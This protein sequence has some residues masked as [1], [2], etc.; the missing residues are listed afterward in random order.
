MAFAF[1]FHV[2]TAASADNEI[3]ALDIE[4]GFSVT[5]QLQVDVVGLEV[6]GDVAVS[7]HL[8]GH[9]FTVELLG[10]Y[11]AIPIDDDV[12]FGTIHVGSLKVAVTIDFD[13]KVAC[14]LRR[15]GTMILSL[16]LGKFRGASLATT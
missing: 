3:V 8:D 9:I 15:F 5:G 2:A 10:N 6:G 11:I 12:E 13:V 7:V 14:K 16:M 1:Q 4:I